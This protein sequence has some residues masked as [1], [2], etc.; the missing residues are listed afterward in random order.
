MKIHVLSDLHTEFGA[1]KIP[2]T[3]ADVIVLAGDTGL[4]LNGVKWALN[5]WPDRPIL[6][7]AGNH[8]YYNH[9][10]PD[11]TDALRG[12]CEGS[13]VRFMEDSAEVID[14]VRF[15]GC[16]LW[17]DYLLFGPEKMQDCMD[18]SQF[19]MNDYRLIINSESEDVLVPG[20]V[21]RIHAQSRKWL[22]AELARDFD[23]PTVVITHH[24]P[25]RESIGK[26]WRADPTSAAYASDLDSLMDGSRVKLWIHGHTHVNVDYTING[27]RIMSNQH[28]YIDRPAAGFDPG[29]V[30]EV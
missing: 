3:D 1:T 12:F 28:G 15:L 13:R 24:A 6:Y 5:Q 22:Q 9:A 18:R 10:L 8:E 14:G 17:T 7:I 30:V 4:G 23:G 25:S 29:C 20:D 11:L 26:A 16:T 2:R 27:T 21:V 19:E